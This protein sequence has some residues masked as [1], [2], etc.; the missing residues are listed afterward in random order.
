MRDALAR[1][2]LSILATLFAAHAPHASTTTPLPCPPWRSTTSTTLSVNV[3]QPLLLCEPALC[4][5]TVSDVFRRR[6]PERASEMRLL[7]REGAECERQLH[8]YYVHA[9]A[10]DLVGPSR[11]QD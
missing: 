5:E 10:A 2:T 6:T 4:G 9:R 8:K 11:E 1:R 7:R 3:S